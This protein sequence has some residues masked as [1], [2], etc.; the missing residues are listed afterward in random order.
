MKRDFPRIRIKVTKEVSEAL[1]GD[2]V[3]RYADRE[4]TEDGKVILTYHDEVES[5][6]YFMYRFG[7]D[8][9]VLEP[10]ELRDRVVEQARK[11]LALYRQRERK[12]KRESNQ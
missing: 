6:L 5:H 2:W 7:A 12:S 4:E 3:L 10:K 8:C 11:V 9:E 1:K